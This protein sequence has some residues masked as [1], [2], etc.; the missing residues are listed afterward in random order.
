MS[1]L[2]RTLAAALLLAG[3]LLADD[4]KEPSLQYTLEIAGKAQAITLDAPIKVEGSFTNPEVVLK[5][6]PTRRFTYGGIQFDYPAGFGWEA[7]IS[8]PEEKTWTLS[9]NDFT[10]MY[11]VLPDAQAIDEFA[12]AMAA[13]FE[14]AVTKI[15]ESERTLGGQKRKG[16]RM[17]VRLVGTSIYIEF[18]SF[19]SAS[20]ARLLVLQD[21]PD[22]EQAISPEAAK[23]LQ[24]MERSFVDS[25]AK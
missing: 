23:A 24:L 22:E 4:S 10:I 11:F 6:A 9:G 18:Y 12:A 20:G 1:P 2:L 14:N 15:E 7:E 19:P 5:A 8:G 13:Q 25:Q 16:K 21:S 3:P 17:T